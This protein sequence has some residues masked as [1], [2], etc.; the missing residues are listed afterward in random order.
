VVLNL[1]IHYKRKNFPSRMSVPLVFISRL[2]CHFRLA[3]KV[4]TCKTKSSQRYRNL[5]ARASPTLIVCIP[6]AAVLSGTRNPHNATC[7]NEM[8]SDVDSIVGV[9]SA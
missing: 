6:S 2:C 7:V 1:Q 4:I 8:R 5:L 9:F 3:S